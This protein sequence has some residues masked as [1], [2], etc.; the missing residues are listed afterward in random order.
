MGAEDTIS[1]P[2]AASAETPAADTSV[3]VPS[4]PSPDST[5]EVTPDSFGWDTWD[6]SEDALPE[7][8]RP[9]VTHLGKHFSRSA[10]LERAEAERLR[11]IY[12]T[13]MEGREDPR[14]KQLQEQ[15]ESRG[16]E[17]Q[18]R[19]QQLQQLQQEYQAYQQ[20]VSA[21]FDQ[22]A[23]ARAEAFRAQNSWIF[24]SQELQQLG[25]DLIDDGFGLDDLPTLLRMEPKQLEL[26]RKFNADLKATGA[27]NVGSHAIKLARAEFKPTAASPAAELVAGANGSTPHSSVPIAP[28]SDADLA[29]LKEAAIDRALRL[30]KK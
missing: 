27:K 4:D 22:Q 9:W 11:G 3:V 30:V 18:T 5:P 14:L 10:E 7:S 17:F 12:E 8:V 20:Q 16:K 28:P 15:I 2:V 19:E 23:T 13:L 24:E 21:F 26:T 25:S 6:G 29:S 1:T